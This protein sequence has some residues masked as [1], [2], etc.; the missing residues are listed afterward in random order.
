MTH[1]ESLLGGLSQVLIKVFRV[2]VVLVNSYGRRFRFYFFLSFWLFIT[3][4]SQ[5]LR[6][7][8]IWFSI[9]QGVGLFRTFKFLQPLISDHSIHSFH[10]CLSLGLYCVE[11]VGFFPSLQCDT[12]IF[13]HYLAFISCSSWLR[14]VFFWKC[15]EHHKVAS[16][17]ILAE[18]WFASW[19][20]FN[21]LGFGLRLDLFEVS[22][23]CH[24]IF[25]S[26]RFW[27]ISFTTGVGLDFGH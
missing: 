6:F 13:W 8:V 16:V 17:T 7:C 21:K 22:G 20:V 24:F 2:Q 5:F 4:G 14:F 19:L 18:H 23:A 10:S 25:V 27:L 3:L 15:F 26:F 12:V 9:S 1:I 11:S